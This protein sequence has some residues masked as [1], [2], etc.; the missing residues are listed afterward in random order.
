MWSSEILCVRSRWWNLSEGM[1]A[2]GRNVKV[3]REEEW[4][5]VRKSEEETKIGRTRKRWRSGE[6]R[7][8]SEEGKIEEDIESRR[9]GGRERDDDWEIEEQGRDGDQ[10]TK[11]QLTK[12]NEL[13]V[14]CANWKLWRS[15]QRSGRN[16]E[17]SE[18]RVG[19]RVGKSG[20]ND[21]EW[22]KTN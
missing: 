13:Y 3:E 19:R 22:L 2:W 9:S 20:R 14:I 4:G 21:W 6:R 15:S 12:E 17:E 8:E 5:R 11:K 7:V 1:R 18:E 10:E 16:R